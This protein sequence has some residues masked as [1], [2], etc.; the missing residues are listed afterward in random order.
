MISGNHSLPITTT[1]AVT[2]SH[3]AKSMPAAATAAKYIAMPRFLEEK[4]G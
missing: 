1:V 3:I 2:M 4:R